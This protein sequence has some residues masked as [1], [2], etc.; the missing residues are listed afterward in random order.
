MR[1]AIWNKTDPIL[2]PI[3]EVLTAEQWINRYPIAGVPSITVICAAGE[4]NGGF[5]GTLG[6]MVDLY[7]K[8]GCDFSACETAEDKL[9]AIEAFEDAR[10]AEQAAQAKAH[11]EATAT[12]EELTAASLA[13]IAASME[14]QNLL[15]LDDMEV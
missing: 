7:T 6:Q 9:A 10:E 8:H 3:G 1:Y 13:S 4:I 2:T 11:A 12:N 14:Y 5:F 15:T